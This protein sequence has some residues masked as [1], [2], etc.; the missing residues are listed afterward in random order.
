MYIQSLPFV[1]VYKRLSLRAMSFKSPMNKSRIPNLRTILI[2]GPGR[3]KDRQ[4]RTS[5]R[6][7]RETGS[8]R[9]SYVNCIIIDEVPYNTTG[10]F[11][12]PT[13]YLLTLIY[14]STVYLY[15]YLCIYICV[16]LSV[17][18]CMCRV[19]VSHL[20]SLSII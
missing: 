11:Y 7:K 10:L 9:S 17:Y 4:T 13:N 8:Q 12:L 18:L 3:K 15:M 2:L 20:P 5:P 6:K 14:L 19:G 16:C 1:S